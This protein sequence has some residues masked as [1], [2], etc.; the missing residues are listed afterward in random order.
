[1]IG[2]YTATQKER[3][4]IIGEAALKWYGELIGRDDAVLP[5]VSQAELQHR[6][7]RE[8]ESR[9]YLS[10][11]CREFQKPQGDSTETN[12]VTPADT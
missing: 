6:Y 12:V 9:D 1:V 3:L 7:N 11:L 8:R 4:L 10:F 2:E 5:G